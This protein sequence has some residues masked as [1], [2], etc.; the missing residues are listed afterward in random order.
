MMDMNQQNQSTSVAA[1]YLQKIIGFKPKPTSSA[2]EQQSTQYSGAFDVS[3]ISSSGVPPD[4]YEPLIDHHDRG[5]DVD[6][7]D[8]AEIPTLKESVHT[9]STFT[10]NQTQ[11]FFQFQRPTTESEES[12]AMGF[13]YSKPTHPV[14]NTKPSKGPA[15]VKH[16]AEHPPSKLSQV[17]NP[18]TLPCQPSEPERSS[19]GSSDDRQP[20]S[21]GQTCDPA[22]VEQKNPPESPAL[23]NE[24]L[25][26][27]NMIPETEYN[28]PTDE[29]RTTGQSRPASPAESHNS[30]KDGDNQVLEGQTLIDVLPASPI[31]AR[32]SALATPSPRRQSSRQSHNSSS[33]NTEPSTSSALTKPRAPTKV[34]KPSRIPRTPSSPARS[35]RASANAGQT[36][37]PKKALRSLQMYYHKQEE[38][39]NEVQAWKEA[40]DMEI[41][42]LETISQ[43]LHSQLQQSEQQVISLTQQLAQHHER[44]PQW[45][46][47]IKKLGDF[48]NGL[49]RDHSRLREDAKAMTSELTQLHT[50]KDTVKRE[51]EVA[52]LGS[53]TEHSRHQDQLSKTRQTVESLQQG[54]NTRNDELEKESIRLQSEQARTERLEGSLAASTTQQ[55]TLTTKLSQQEGNLSSQISDL[56]SLIHFLHQHTQPTNQIDLQQKIEECLSLL[57]EPRDSMTTSSAPLEKLELSI[58]TVI[59]K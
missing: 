29:K 41:Q 43:A 32:Q 38:Y 40:R 19:S 57:K 54:L 17:V 14:F 35:L 9:Q 31:N 59:D 5:S 47:R 7:T 42:D 22:A 56:S 20:D 6:D 49:S 16:C 55:Q 30:V 18:D 15:A 27:T 50:F 44:V 28:A 36:P 33:R 13:S 4:G 26:S 21:N 1:S 3:D 48:V 46:D 58:Q 52:T 53:Q 8:D 39:Q 25:A 10:A 11:P 23:P 34:R 51:V 12:P 24:S 37:N 45:Q 2:E